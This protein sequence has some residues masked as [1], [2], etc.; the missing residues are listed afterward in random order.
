MPS[1][2]LKQ[3]LNPYPLDQTDMTRIQAWIDPADKHLLQSVYPI[4]GV[5]TFMLC[6]VYKVIAQEI[7][8]AGINHFTPE[9]A[10]YVYKTIL[11]HITPT[12]PPGERPSE[13]D[14]G[15]SK[16]VHG[17]HKASKN[18]SANAGKDPSGRPG[19]GGSGIT[20]NETD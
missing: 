13:H 8:D 16:R 14:K 9:N 5:E 15:G 6:G 12:Q 20:D 11:R 4:K 2:H 17:A 3:L 10:E 19:R 7:R 18:K 1:T